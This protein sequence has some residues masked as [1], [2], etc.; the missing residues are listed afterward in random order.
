MI[1]IGVVSSI[2]PGHGTARVLFDDLDELV[3]YDLQILYPATL[4]NKGYWM[5]DV[6]EHV[7]CAF[8]EN[9][10]ENGVILGAIYGGSDEVPVD[11]KDIWHLSIPGGVAVEVDRKT[12]E[13]MVVD[14]WGSRIIFRS[15]DVIIKSARYIQLN[16]SEADIPAH[17]SAIFD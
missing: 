16:P 10:L 9:G 13:F 12:R 2:D 15:G 5:P 8:L 1:R 11:D 14:S 3:S 7:A 6:G 17:L 4:R